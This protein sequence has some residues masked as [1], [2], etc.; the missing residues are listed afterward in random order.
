MVC[1]KCGEDYD[2]SV[3]DTRHSG[4]TRYRRRRCNRCGEKY[5]TYEINSEQYYAMSRILRL[6]KELGIEAE[7]WKGETHGNS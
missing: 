5:N 1:P 3:L 7:N 4:K 6:A 2:L